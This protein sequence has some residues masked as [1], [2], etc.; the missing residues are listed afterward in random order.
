M[1]SS[2][3]GLIKSSWRFKQAVGASP[4]RHRD[5]LISTLITGSPAR[6]LTNPITRCRDQP[7]SAMQGQTT[8]KGTDQTLD[9]K[10]LTLMSV[11]AGE[12]P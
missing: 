3:R 4:T 2:R 10:R 1:R 6:R 11:H 5:T 8:D 12:S 9:A 7:H